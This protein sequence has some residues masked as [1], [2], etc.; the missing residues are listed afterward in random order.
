MLRY[1]SEN[2]L[3]HVKIFLFELNH[4]VIKGMVDLDVF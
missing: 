4:L 2:N 1:C 3:I